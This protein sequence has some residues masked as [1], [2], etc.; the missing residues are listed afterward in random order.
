MSFKY[1]YLK[2]KV[3]VGVKPT[4]YV[5]SHIQENGYDWYSVTKDECVS[6]HVDEGVEY[7][8]C[9]YNFEVNLAAVFLDKKDAIS[10]LNQEI[11]IKLEENE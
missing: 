4:V 11:N 1:S 9:K 5:L 7:C 2:N 8:V 3:D 10:T 6:M